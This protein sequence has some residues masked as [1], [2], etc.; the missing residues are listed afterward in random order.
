MGM[1]SIYTRR[2]IL[3][4]VL[5]QTAAYLGGLLVVIWGFGLLL[6]LAHAEYTKA[7]EASTS[8]VETWMPPV[9]PPLIGIGLAALSWAVARIARVHLPVPAIVALILNPLALVF[10]FLARML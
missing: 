6:D 8:V 4:W 2:N 5:G 9:W 10:A 1:S 3:A 7:H